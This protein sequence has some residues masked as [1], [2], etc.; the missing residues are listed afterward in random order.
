MRYFFFIAALLFSTGTYSQTE[1]NIQKQTI[2][3]D[4]KAEFP[5][6]QN[7]FKNEFMK[8]V[9]A[10][11]DITAYAVNGKFSFVLT[12]DEKG[13]MSELKIYPKVRNDEEF[14][15]DMNFAMKRIKKKWKPAIKNGVPVSS[16]IIF[17]I[18]FTSEHSDEEF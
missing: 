15:Q 6:G 5:G 3:Q 10:Y 2:I 1:A 7:A 18:N 11:V 12:I 8:M 9:Y 17:D 16:N 14:K 13:K 4:Q